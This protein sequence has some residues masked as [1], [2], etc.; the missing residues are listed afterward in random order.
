[1]SQTAARVA[2]RSGRV[3]VVVPQVRRRGECVQVEEQDHW[4]P[5]QYNKFRRERMEPFF[6]LVALV[7]P[8][9]GMC[10][11]D[12]GCGTGEL[13]A[14]LAE[15]FAD[16]CVEGID[17]SAAMLARARAWAGERLTFRQADMRD[18][19]DF[20]VYDLVFSNAALQWVPD[21][22]ELL[23]RI[24]TQ[25]HAGAQIAVQVPRRGG[26]R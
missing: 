3:G 16:A 23:R 2:G 25:L 4:N 10:V 1:V 24:L 17:S 6:D 14:M 21:N 18:I 13:T 26:I 8:R 19:E 20:S 5:E 9:P 12:L 7:Q 22:E 15:R 11:I